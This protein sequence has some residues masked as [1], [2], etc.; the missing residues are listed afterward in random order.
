MWTSDCIIFDVESLSKEIEIQ[1]RNLIA[2]KVDICEWAPIYQAFRQRFQD[3]GPFPDRY[4]DFS[5]N[6]FIVSSPDSLQNTINELKTNEFPIIFIDKSQRGFT[7][8]QILT[9]GIT[10]VGLYKLYMQIDVFECRSNLV[11]TTR[12]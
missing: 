5:S 2:K 9:S 10:E 4:S 1:I 3:T 8:G 7:Y 12:K 11:F 6:C